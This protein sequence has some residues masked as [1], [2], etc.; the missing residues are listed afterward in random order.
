MQLPGLSLLQGGTASPHKRFLLWATQ[1][2]RLTVSES[3]TAGA[4]I[5]FGPW[6]TSDL[7]NDPVAIYNKCLGSEQ[8]LGPWVTSEALGSQS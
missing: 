5:C 7:W 2:L 3:L 4:S 8:Q 6:T 1:K